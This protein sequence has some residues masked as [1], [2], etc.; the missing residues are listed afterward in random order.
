MYII[1]IIII[2]SDKYSFW[3]D[4]WHSSAK[5]VH[6]NSLIPFWTDSPPEF[7]QLPLHRPRQIRKASLSS[8]Q[9][10]QIRGS[11]PRVRPLSFLG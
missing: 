6:Q 3:I 9:R 11:E 4:P 1:I 5:H 7:G 10:L 2:R 8:R